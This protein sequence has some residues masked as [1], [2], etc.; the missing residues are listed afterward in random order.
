LPRSESSRAPRVLVLVLGAR[1]TPYPALVRAI[2]R[3]WGLVGVE[4][5]ETL[6][7]YGGDRLRLERDELVLPVPDGPADIGRKTIAAFEWVLENRQFDVIFRTNCSSYVDLPNLHRYASMHATPDAFYS[8]I[9]GTH[10]VRF[11]SGSGY[12]LSRDLV[13]LVVDR[14]SEWYHKLVDDQALAVVLAAHGVDPTPAPRHDYRSVAEVRNVDTS[15]YHFR[16]RTDSWRRREDVRI[17]NAVHRAF[18][19]SRGRAA[20]AGGLRSLL[21]GRLRAR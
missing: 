16:C 9:I 2:R 6:F 8:G 7:Y 19:E 10:P 21:P 11:A 14:Q 13:E 4:G 5:A 1:V 3:T 15:L 17:M 12:F 20:P 18:A